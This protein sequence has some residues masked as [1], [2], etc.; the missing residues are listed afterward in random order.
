MSMIIPL[1]ALLL[2]PGMR[3]VLLRVLSH[4]AQV[5][6]AESI[7][8]HTTLEGSPEIELPASKR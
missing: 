4:H 1:E 3:R 2:L 5:I 6:V 7:C 8:E